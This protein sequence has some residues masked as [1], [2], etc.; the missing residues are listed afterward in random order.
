MASEAEGQIAEAVTKA[1]ATN[2]STAA[3]EVGLNGTC[4]F[5]VFRPHQ[6]QRGGMWS[7]YFS[8]YF[9]CCA[10]PALNPFLQSVQMFSC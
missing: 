7:Q 8:A 9:G 2:H 1:Q 10:S 4:C 6:I 5:F 3:G